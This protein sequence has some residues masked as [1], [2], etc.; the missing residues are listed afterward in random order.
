MNTTEAFD[1]T[2]TNDW[3]I[4]YD[5]DALPSTPSLQRSSRNISS[6]IQQLAL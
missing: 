6:L 1:G 2:Q 4:E 5:L 3:P